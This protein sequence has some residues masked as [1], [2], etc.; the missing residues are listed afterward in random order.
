MYDK[1]NATSFRVEGDLATLACPPQF[2]LDSNVLYLDLHYDEASG[3][4]RD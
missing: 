1:V 4:D 2:D 3:P